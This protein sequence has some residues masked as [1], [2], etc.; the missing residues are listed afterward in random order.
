MAETVFD[1]L[2][3]A[4]IGTQGFDKNQIACIVGFVD[5]KDKSLLT[6]SEL[7]AGLE[8]LVAAG[9]VREL[10]HL[11]FAPGSDSSRNFSGVSQLEFDEGVEIYRRW[12]SEQFEASHAQ[13]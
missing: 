8:R 5:M 4:A 10:E 11:C 3:A 7:R 12:L 6:R 13:R 2:I 1:D 9:R